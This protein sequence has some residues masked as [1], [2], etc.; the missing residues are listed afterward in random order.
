VPHKNSRNSKFRSIKKKNNTIGSLDTRIKRR[1]FNANSQTI[2]K[3][4]NNDISKK[5]EHNPKT[6]FLNKKIRGM[7]Q[8]TKEVPK[9]NYNINVKYTFNSTTK[10]VELSKLIQTGNKFHLDNPMKMVGEF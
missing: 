7:E 1:S 3:S 2:D 10:Q 6:M 4:L 9:R 8:R 5:T